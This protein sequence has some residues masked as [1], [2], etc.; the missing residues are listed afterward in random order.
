MS[1]IEVEFH[2]FKDDLFRLGIASEESLLACTTSQVDDVQNCM[3]GKMPLAYRLFLQAMGAGAGRFFRGTSVYYPTMI[4]LTE[5]AQEILE[6]NG[7]N[8]KL[9]DD[10]FVF[11]MHQGYQFFYFRCNSDNPPVYHYMDGESEATMWADSYTQFLWMMNTAAE[12]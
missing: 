1:S 11:A 12:W 2:R 9:P 6:D 4:G 7:G 5:A 8:T 10:A 3:P